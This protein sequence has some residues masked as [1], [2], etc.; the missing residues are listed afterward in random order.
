MFNASS[1]NSFTSGTPPMSSGMPRCRAN[2]PSPSYNANASKK[3]AAAAGMNHY[4][5]IVCASCAFISVYVLAGE[6]IGHRAVGRRFGPENLEDRD[7]AAVERM[8]R[9]RHVDAPGAEAFFAH[10]PAR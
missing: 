2:A 1:L 4:D 3:T 9:T 7:P 8:R 10:D 6:R 5:V